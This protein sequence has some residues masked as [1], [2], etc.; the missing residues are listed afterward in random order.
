M[1]GVHPA[2]A[3]RVVH[4]QPGDLF[5]DAADLGK[6]GLIVLQQGQGAAKAVQIGQV[7]GGVQQLLAVVL[8]V[9]VQQAAAQLPQLGHGDGPSVQAAGVA[10]VPLDLPL[11]QQFLPLVHA[12]VG[13]P[14]QGWQAGEHRRDQGGLGPGAD[15]LPAGPLAQH[16]ADGIDNDGLARP[17][18]AG[19]D[20]QSAVKADIRRFDDGDIF[21]VQQGKHGVLR[22][23]FMEPGVR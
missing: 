20:I 13:Q 23:S 10:P 5:S 19:E 4:F 9:D 3:L 17:R 11:E 1:Q 12:V 8:A 22:P 18:L 7:T 2:G 15:E 21:N 16:G 6:G 14:A